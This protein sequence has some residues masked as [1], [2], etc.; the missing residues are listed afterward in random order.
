MNICGYLARCICDPT[1]ASAGLGDVWAAGIV[2]LL[3]QPTPSDLSPKPLQDFLPLLS[4]LSRK[5]KDL[6]PL[7]LR[8]RPSGS[9]LR[10]EIKEQIN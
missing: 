7:F 5:R 2:C 1:V 10:T 6:R 8:T 4:V 3:A 9:P